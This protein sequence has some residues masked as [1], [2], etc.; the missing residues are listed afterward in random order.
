MHFTKAL[1]WHNIGKPK[2][3]LQIQIET[4]KPFYFATHADFQKSSYFIARTKDKD[5]LSCRL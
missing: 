1:K 5:M 2:Q 3:D 4:A